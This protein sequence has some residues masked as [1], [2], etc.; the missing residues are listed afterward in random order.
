M[1]LLQL[2]EPL[3]K[4]KMAITSMKMAL[5]RKTINKISNSSSFKCS[6]K[7]ITIISLSAL[8]SRR[9]MPTET[10]QETMMEETSYSLLII[11]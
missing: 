8:N 1:Q 5:H 3:F 2:Q 7:R 9:T 11:I 4:D 10:A 6:N